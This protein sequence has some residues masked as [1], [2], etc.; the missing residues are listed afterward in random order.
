MELQEPQWTLRSDLPKGT[1]LEDLFKS[2]FTIDD[3]AAV[4]LQMDQT[5]AGSAATPNGN[6]ADSPLKKVAQI[7]GL[8]I[9]CAAAAFLVE[10]VRKPEKL[11]WAID[12]IRDFF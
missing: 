1:G 9:F 11:S 3:D 8:S 10:T 5:L 7:V 6:A 4:R 2:S 12:R